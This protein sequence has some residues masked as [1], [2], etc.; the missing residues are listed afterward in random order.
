M[1]EPA[2]RGP[3]DRCLEPMLSLFPGLVKRGKARAPP[4]KPVDRL[5]KI[6][7]NMA[8]ATGSPILALPYSLITLTRRP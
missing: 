6:A 4:N 3:V 8:I 2:G 5:S 7:G 1:A